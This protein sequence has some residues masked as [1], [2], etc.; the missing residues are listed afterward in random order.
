[1]AASSSKT[2]KN[3]H[4]KQLIIPAF[5]A[6]LF[7]S[8]TASLQQSSTAVYSTADGNVRLLFENYAGLQ[9][10]TLNKDT[11]NTASG[12]RMTVSLL[13][14]YITNISLKKTD[15]S[16]LTIPQDQSYFLIKESD[17]ASREISLN[18]PEGK[19][20]TEV[21]E[22]KIFTFKGHKYQIA[23]ELVKPNTLKVVRTVTLNWDKIST[24]DYLEYKKYVED[25]IAAEEQIVGFK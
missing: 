18:I 7:A 24:T 9:P 22:G 16:I 13:Q 1:M 6:I 4:M 2:D 17:P 3:N 11:F 5:A 21:P 23:F 20:F 15:G 8:C 25:V 14:Y 19:K 12:E 10:L